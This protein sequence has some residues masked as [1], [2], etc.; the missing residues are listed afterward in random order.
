MELHCAV[1]FKL[2]LA[3]GD[4]DKGRMLE[5]KGI[6]YGKDGKI[7]P[8]QRIGY[9]C[10]VH[11]IVEYSHILNGRPVG[12]IYHPYLLGPQGEGQK[13]HTYCEDYTVFHSRGK[14]A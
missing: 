12:G 3:E 8:S 11:G 1:S 7:D 13:Q 14:Y 9:V 5:Y 6:C 10:P 4:S 2:P